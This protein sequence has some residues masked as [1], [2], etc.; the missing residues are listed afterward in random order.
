ML[1]ALS[2]TLL[3]VL[4]EKKNS[5]GPQD[6]KDQNKLFYGQ[7]QQNTIQVIDF[8]FTPRGTICWHG[9]HKQF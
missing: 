3:S 7:S 4:A 2:R 5:F 8:F 1:A 6:H 9:P